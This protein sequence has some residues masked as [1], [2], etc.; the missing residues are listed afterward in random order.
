[1]AQALE[2][3]GRKNN[4]PQMMQAAKKMK[5]LAEK[6]TQEPHDA[7]EEGIE[8]A[9]WITEGEYKAQPLGGGQQRL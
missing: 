6:Q 5:A 1:M 8:E 2:R 3:A 7:H 9:Q 4:E